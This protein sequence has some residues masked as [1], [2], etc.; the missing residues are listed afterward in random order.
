MI[1]WISGNYAKRVAA[2]GSLDFYGGHKPN[3][4]ECPECP[5]RDN[6]PEFQISPQ[7]QYCVFRKEVDVEDNSVVI[8]EL[9]NGIKATYT[10][11][12][13]T[14]DYCRNYTFIGTEGRVE[15]LDDDSRV[16]VLTRDRV[17]KYK[18]LANRSYDVKPAEG[19]HG[20]AD[21]LICQ[22]FV[23]MLISGKEPVATPVAG[24]MSVAVGCA[25]TESLHS[26]GKVVEVAPLPCG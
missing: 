12:H 19:S 6:C 23:D 1:H 11:C 9:E 26:G 7:H 25:A 15:N 20:G 16:I 18:N 8:M 24:R 14:P 2:F 17:K 21:P 10:Q 5:D 13:F 22:D 3:Y 4:L